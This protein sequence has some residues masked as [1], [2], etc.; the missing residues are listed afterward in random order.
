[1]HIFDLTSFD[2]ND[3]ISSILD[4]FFKIMTSI[5]ELLPY[6]YKVLANGPKKLCALLRSAKCSKE[7]AAIGLLCIKRVNVIAK[8]R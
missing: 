5:V 3:V 7:I 2:G 8:S 4:I 6:V 1:M